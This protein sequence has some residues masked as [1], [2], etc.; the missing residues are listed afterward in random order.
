MYNLR[1]FEQREA[2][3]PFVVT[4]K[5][6]AAISFVGF[7]TTAIVIANPDFFLNPIKVLSTLVLVFTFALLLLYFMI[8][9]NKRVFK[10]APFV[11]THHTKIPEI[12]E[13]ADIKPGEKVVDIGSGDGRMVLEFA[14]TGAFAYGY[15]INPLLYLISKARI[16]KNKMEKNA[17]VSKNNFWNVN[18]SDFDVIHVYGI[19]YIM[20]DLEKKL[21]K[22]LKGGARV[23]SNTFTFPN[24]K[25]KKSKNNLHVYHKEN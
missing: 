4:P 22:E 7:F 18:F 16:K 8:Y 21:I 24:W 10:G 2:P 17:V 9:F 3:M 15:E 11:Q 14:K 6:F 13:M 25:P 1:V 20:P 23:V 19:E 12:I 5:L